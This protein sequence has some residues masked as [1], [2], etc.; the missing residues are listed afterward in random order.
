MKTT[1]LTL[2]TLSAA[3]G[4]GQTA[5]ASSDGAWAEFASAVEK[6]CIKSASGQIE[7][8]RA[9]V[10]PYGSAKYGLAIVT[11]RPSGVPKSKKLADISV[12]C[13]YDKKTKAAEVG[14]EIEIG[15]VMNKPKPR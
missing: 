5:Q 10:D 9:V 2:A 8:G 13:V 6:A 4:F 12:I 15:K 14:G 7:N 3:L 1:L 11:G